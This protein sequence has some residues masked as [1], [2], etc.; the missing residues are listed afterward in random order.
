[1]KSK[2]W[3]L[4]LSRTG[5]TTL[6]YVLN[7]MGYRHIHYPTYNEMMSMN[8][9]GASDISGHSNLQRT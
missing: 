6:S 7:A 4:G 3:G 8:N 1:M 5:T 2:I 9:D